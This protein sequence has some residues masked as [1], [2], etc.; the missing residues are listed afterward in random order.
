[1]RASVCCRLALLVCLL[2]A[3]PPAAATVI[4]GDASAFGVSIQLSGLLNQNTGLVPG[5]SVSSPPPDSA[6]QTTPDLSPLVLITSGSASVN[7]S[8]DVDGLPGL[9]SASGDATIG[10]LTL[11][12]T[13]VLTQVIGISSGQIFS[14]ASV[15]GEYGALGA[16]GSAQFGG[17]TVFVNGA[18]FIL[19]PAPAPNTV[20]YDNGIITVIANQQILSGDGLGLRGITVNALRITLAGALAGTLSGAIVLGQSQAVLSAVPVPEPGTAL[21]L[22]IGLV[23]LTRARRS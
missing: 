9:R 4:T 3:G 13:P 10:N 5:V 21:L 23:G 8:T 7:A 19:D 22:A 17:T 1:M 20:V 2:A 16:T 12:L 11:N 15:S 6:S 18:A 14:S